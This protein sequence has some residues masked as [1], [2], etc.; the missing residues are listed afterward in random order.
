MRWSYSASR[1]FRQC[2]RSWYFKNAVASARANDAHR[3]RAYRLSKLRTLSAWRGQIV[4]DAISALIIPAL[5][6]HRIVTLREVKSWA[7]ARF[8]RQLAFALKHPINDP[9]LD[10]SAA[11]DA[12]T[13]F[14]EMEYGTAPSAEDIGRAWNEIESALT[15]LYAMDEVKNALKSADYVIAQRRLQFDLMDGVNVAAS[16]DAIAFRPQAAPAIVDW[17]VR[18][19][20][21]NDAWLQLAIY[22]LAL[23]RTKHRDFPPHAVCEPKD[24]VLL[25][26]QLLTAS[27]R[28]H[29]VEQDHIDEAEEYIISSACEMSSLVDGRKYPDLKPDDFLP[30]VRA[31]TCQRC[32]FRSICWEGSNVH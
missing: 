29:R 31:E 19:F 22:A 2:Q 12:F 15:N 1:T 21:Q 13:L 24:V 30:A 9:D 4:D 18:V 6:R 28:E 7:H 23:S 8:D 10:V 26:A 32:S 17:K 16:P 20:G 27:L 11:G 5:N 25:E 3:R 14:F